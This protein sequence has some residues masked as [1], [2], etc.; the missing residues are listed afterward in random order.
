MA[1]RASVSSIA[2]FCPISRDQPVSIRRAPVTPALVRPIDLPSLIAAINTIGGI[3]NAPAPN[4]VAPGSP[5]VAVPTRAGG[6]PFGRQSPIG[7]AGGPPQ[8]YERERDTEQHTIYHK[9]S[10]GSYDKS[11]RIEVECI[12]QVT[13]NNINSDGTK[14]FQWFYKHTAGNDYGPGSIQTSPQARSDTSKK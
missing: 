1:H 12:H 13:F 4:N 5:S 7:G 9:K 6:A 11:Q 2:L 3:F 8:W 10:D 14:I